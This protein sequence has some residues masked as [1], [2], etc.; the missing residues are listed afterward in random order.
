[1]PPTPWRVRNPPSVW[2]SG[3]TTSSK[4]P[5]S[6][7]VFH[8]S[9]GWCTSGLRP[10]PPLNAWLAA[11]SQP[12][13]RLH[14]C[15]G[16]TTMGPPPQHIWAGGVI[17]GIHSVS[18]RALLPPSSSPPLP[19]CS[20]VLVIE[21][22]FIAG[23][24]AGLCRGRYCSLWRCDCAEGR[25]VWLVFSTT[26]SLMQ[27][28]FFLFLSLGCS[29]CLRLLTYFSLLTPLGSLVCLCFSFLTSCLLYPLSLFIV[30]DWV[31]IISISNANDAAQID[32]KFCPANSNLFKGEFLSMLNQIF[33]VL[34]RVSEVCRWRNTC[35]PPRSRQKLF[36]VW[37]RIKEIDCCEGNDIL[38]NW[39]ISKVHTKCYN[40]KC[41]IF[42]S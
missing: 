41:N 4:D 19:L 38:F 32:T 25:R 6:L 1:M 39:I 29:L 28:M 36:A 40:R 35:T 2:G 20:P 42:T 37:F 26:R 15:A 34:L 17:Q 24:G 8:Q 30:L 14:A 31:C 7:Q 10:W 27:S 33:S 18:L 16:A 11:K 22:V 21:N 5:V 3:C 12:V 9:A 13:I 23:P